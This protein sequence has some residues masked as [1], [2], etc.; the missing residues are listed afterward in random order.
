[1]MFAIISASKSSSSANT[2]PESLAWQPADSLDS[3]GCI[4]QIFRGSHIQKAPYLGPVD[5]PTAQSFIL[6]AGVEM[7]SYP[8]SGAVAINMIIGTVLLI[9]GTFRSVASI[10][11]RFPNW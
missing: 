5:G 3:I 9:A 7:L 10:A 11:M 8:G 6:V 2:F 4:L 1:M